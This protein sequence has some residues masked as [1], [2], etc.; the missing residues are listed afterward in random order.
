MRKRDWKHALFLKE[1]P[2]GARADA[3]R[4]ELEEVNAVLR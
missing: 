3:A 4:K 2:S 1:E